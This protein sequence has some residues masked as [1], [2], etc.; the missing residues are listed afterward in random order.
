MVKGEDFDQRAGEV[1][2]V[3]HE[4]ERPADEGEGVNAG[5]RPEKQDDEERD[6]YVG[7]AGNG[8]VRDHFAGV[9]G[10][11]SK[12]NALD[13]AG[14]G[15]LDINDDF[16]ELA[17][18]G[19]RGFHEPSGSRFGRGMSTVGRDAVEPPASIQSNERLDGVSSYRGAFKVTRPNE[20]RRNLTREPAGKTDLRQRPSIRPGIF[21]TGP[22]LAKSAQAT[23]GCPQHHFCCIFERA[24]SLAGLFSN[25][26]RL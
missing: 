22:A 13:D 6:D 17:A 1:E 10:Q 23:S 2:E 11:E 15:Q 8:T 12:G 16:V 25:R 4:F 9:L 14:E 26:F 19:W 21:V 24:S 18:A 20:F 3:V 5:P 7:P